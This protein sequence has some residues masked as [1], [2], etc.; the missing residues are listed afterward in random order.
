MS[1]KRL[2]KLEAKLAPYHGSPF[3]TAFHRGFE[4]RI[5]VYPQYGRAVGSAFSNGFGGFDRA[6]SQA[7][8]NGFG[9]CPSPAW[10]TGYSNGFGG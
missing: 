3:E 6:F 5:V 10:S 7:F 9:F 2:K 4:K 8:T 1:E